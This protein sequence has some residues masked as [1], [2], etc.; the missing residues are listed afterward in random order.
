MASKLCKAAPCCSASFSGCDPMSHEA[1]TGVF[2]EAGRRQE[3]PA[4]GAER[5]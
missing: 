4:L 5:F 3:E 1:E 2:E